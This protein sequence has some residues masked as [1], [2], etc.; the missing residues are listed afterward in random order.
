MF[1]QGLLGQLRQIQEKAIETIERQS[2]ELGGLIDTV[3]RVSD[4]ESETL[5]AGE[6]EIDLWEFLSELRSEYRPPSGENVKLVWDYPADL[7]IIQSDRPKL[8]RIAENLINNA[9]K[10]TEQGTVVIS[11]RYL[12]PAKVLELTVARIPESVSPANGAG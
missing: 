7:P 9:V 1:N 11:F 4:I 3:L 5:R 12:A 8:R 6:N 2:K 10:F